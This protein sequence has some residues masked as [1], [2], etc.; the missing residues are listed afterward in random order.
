MKYM[1]RKESNR[2]RIYSKPS[3]NADESE[4]F[5]AKEGDIMYQLS[6]RTKNGGFWYL[7]YIP[8][9]SKYGWVRSPNPNHEYCKVV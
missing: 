2:F 6:S 8:R 1:I 7:Y 3:L 4:I 9:D 5:I